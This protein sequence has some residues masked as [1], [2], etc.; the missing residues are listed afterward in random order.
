[1]VCN[2]Y[3][4]APNYIIHGHY[5]TVASTGANNIKANKIGKFY[6]KFN[7]GNTYELFTPQVMVKGMTI[8]KRTYNYKKMALVTD[9]LNDYAAILKFN[10]DEKGFFTSLFSSTQK[11]FPDTVKGEIIP[12]KNLII[13]DQGKYS[14]QKDAKEIELISGEWTNNLNFSN[15]PYWKLNDFSIIPIFRIQKPLPSDSSF[16]EDLIAFI[17]DDL[18]TA[19]KI[20]EIYEETQR[21]DRKLREKLIAK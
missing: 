15:I 16:R 2:F 3:G 6:I 1:M 11:T 14:K 9:K 21:N 10:P 18:V 19:Q 20:K 4:V 8:G 12:Y 5:S 13:E 17:K 7:D